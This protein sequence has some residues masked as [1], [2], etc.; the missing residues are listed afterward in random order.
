MITDCAV[1]LT[2]GAAQT[3]RS[4]QVQP[5]TSPMVV[6]WAMGCESP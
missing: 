5:A 2:V 1:H 3:P 6:H 4:G